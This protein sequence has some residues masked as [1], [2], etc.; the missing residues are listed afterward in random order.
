MKWLPLVAAL[1]AAPAL[2]ASPKLLVWINGDKAYNGLQKVGDAFEKASGVK[3]VVEHPVDATDK[4]QQ[5][6]GAGKGPDIFCWPHDRI[7]EWAKAGLLTPLRPSAKLKAESEDQ[8]WTAL[9][10]RGRI[11]GYPIAIETTGLIYNKAL[12]PKPPETWDEVIAIDKELKADGK[13]AVLWDYNKSFFTWPMLAGAGGKI[14]E[15]D[16]QGD[17]DSTQVKVNNEGA[18][19]GALMIE[20]LIK[21]GHMPKGARYSEMESA[22]ARGEVAMMISG[23]WAW[24]NARSAKIDIGVAP[25]PA[26]VAGKPSKSFVGVLGCMISAPSK[27][28]D[29]AKEFIE[30]HLM[31]PEA[32]KV[33]D[34]DVPIGVPA[35][36]AFYAE[37]SV[38]PL[39]AASMTNA[40][41]GAPI[42]NI[43]EVGRFWTAMDAALEAITNGLQSPKDAL[44]GAAARMLLN[45]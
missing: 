41:N 1:M 27:N 35:N 37:L 10:Y 17:F 20:R 5:A 23:P 34:A 15:R 14:F 42:P 39:I 18:L 28:K 8:A 3:V 40:R 45:K 44:D 2:A 38:N 25:I 31:R 9:S 7:G 32:L 24:D 11:W 19:A 6:A 4:F 29:I 21:G 22:F 26:V 16:A 43:P 13:S 36:K 12:V 33:L 30:N